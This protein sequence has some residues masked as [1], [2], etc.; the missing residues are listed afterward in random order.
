M[1][2][3]MCFVYILRC[4]DGSYYVGVTTDLNARVI[5]HNEGNGP[6]YTAA[7][8]PVELLYSE[9]FDDP[10]AAR[11]RE[12]QIKKWTRAKKEALVASCSLA[13]KN[14]SKCRAVHGRP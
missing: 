4:R 9:P 12:I 8:R 7:R 13:L 2:Y 10:S 3:L 1:G 6:Q 5:C 11:L 14:L